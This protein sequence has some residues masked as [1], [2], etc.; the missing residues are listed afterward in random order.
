MRDLYIF[1]FE[2]TGVDPLKDRPVQ[3]AC[4]RAGNPAEVAINTLC[5][6]M[7]KIPQEATNLHGI[8][9][10]MVS[11]CPSYVTAVWQMWETIRDEHLI[12]GG[13]NVSQYDLPMAEECFPLYYPFDV[14]DVLDVVYR[15]RP[16]LPSKKLGHVFHELLGYEMKGAHGA[17]GDCIGT[18]AILDHICKADNVSYED[19]VED[20]NT[21]RPYQILP[22]GKYTGTPLDEI[23]KSW[24][25]YM[26][27]NAKN[28]RPDLAATVNFV[29]SRD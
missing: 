2:T 6:P 12:I 18:I 28:M 1:D 10:D 5:N 26:D 3:V 24:A 9:D 7:M 27:T 17:I 21:P 15:R 22:I 8:T 25:S 19:L 23:P 4:I 16:L 11:L 29:L 20:L 14:L 13:Y